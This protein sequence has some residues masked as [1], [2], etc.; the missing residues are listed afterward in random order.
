M[1]D[2]FTG[3]VNFISTGS[4]SGES[5]HSN[6]KSKSKSN[7]QQ[8]DDRYQ[9][10]EDRQDHPE[11]RAATLARG[12]QEREVDEEHP[13]DKGDDPPDPHPEPSRRYDSEHT[14]PP[15]PDR[16]D[17]RNMLTPVA[18]LATLTCR[19]GPRGGSPRLGRSRAGGRHRPLGSSVSAR[20]VSLEVGGRDSGDRQEHRHGLRPDRRVPRDKVQLEEA[21][22]G[23]EGRPAR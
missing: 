16:H 8:D 9:R 2:F 4:V 6:D 17:T 23:I 3:M 18:A 14:Y 15:T 1:G 22:L 20:R 12:E 11:E 5:S 7:D 13:E 19:G 10:E 21:E